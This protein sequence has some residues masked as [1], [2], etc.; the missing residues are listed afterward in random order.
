MRSGSQGFKSAMCFLF[1]ARRFKS[2]Y[3]LSAQPDFGGLH[4]L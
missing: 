2:V 4:K 1:R 3:L